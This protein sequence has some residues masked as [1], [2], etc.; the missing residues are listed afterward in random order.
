DHEN[1][2][3]KGIEEREAARAELRGAT[4]RVVE[5]QQTLERTREEFSGKL[6]HIVSGMAADHEND[7]GKAIE[8]REAA[9]AELR[10]AH[11]RVNELQQTLER[12]RADFNDKLQKIVAGMAADHE[13]DIGEAMT[14]REAA[15]AEAR[16]LTSR[17]QEL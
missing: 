8:E 12:E 7:I 15:R 6:Q 17:M 9:K 14:Q 10:G 1:D 11:G 3:G 13:N 5:L 4:S 16:H 2:I